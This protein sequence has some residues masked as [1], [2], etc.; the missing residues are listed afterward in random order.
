MRATDLFDDYLE[1][2]LA[3]EERQNFELKL[4]EDAVF[5]RAFNEHRNLVETL[6]ANAIRQE[7]RKKLQ[8]IHASEVGNGRVIPMLKEE[9]FA[10]K[11]ARTIAVAAS[12]AFIAVLSTVA[13]LSTGGYLFKQQSNQI[14]DLNRVVMELK[15]SSDGIVEGITK[16]NKKL[17]YAPANYEG[18]AFALNNN[19]YIVTSFHMVNG[20]DSI[21]VQNGQTERALTKLVFCDPKLD[22]AIIK[23]EN[24]ELNKDWQVPFYLKNKSAD[25]GE[26]VFTLGYPR[27]DMVYGEGS[28]SSLSGYSNDT[29]MYQISIPVNPGNSGG[30]LLDETGCVIGVIRGKIAGAE[31][32]GFAIKAHEILKSIELTASDSARAQL[33]PQSARKSNLRSLKRSEQVKKINPYVFNVLVYKGE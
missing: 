3:G 33:L 31:G 21:F 13:V 16:T 20:A 5:A 23:L 22:L 12:T 25:I 2:R 29:S 8:S 19:G 18:S 9:T 4:K 6:Q 28:L 1:G 27:R 11:H 17:P 15:A 14:T 26:K 7:L 30:P 10:T 32:T 24:T